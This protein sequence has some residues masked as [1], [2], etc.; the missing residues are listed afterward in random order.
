M[1]PNQYRPGTGNVFT[2]PIHCAHQNLPRWGRRQFLSRL[3]L[4]AGAAMAL[5]MGLFHWS[6]RQVMA[7][8]VLPG[9]GQAKPRIRAGFTR[10]DRDKYW[11]GWPGAA[12]DIAGSQKRYTEIL[13]HAAAELGVTLD[14]E[15]APLTNAEAIDN[16]LA[17]THNDDLA[18][19]LLTVMSLNEGWTPLDHFLEHRPKGLPTVVFAPQGTQFTPFL[20]QRR[21]VPN[22]FIGSTHDIRWLGSG[23]RMLKARWQMAH[24]RLAVIRGDQEREERLEPVGTT[25]H[26][27]PL[28]WFADAYAATAS[29]PEVR[30]L[31]ASYRENASQTVE[32]DW[33]ELIEAARTYVANR[34]LMDRTGCHAVTM[35]CLG[36]VNRRQTPPPC[37]AYMQL[38]DEQTCGCCEA[39]IFPAISLLLSSYLLGRP[40]FLHNPT[41]NTVNNTYGG[42]HCTAPTLLSGFD[43]PPEPYLL[44]NHHESDWGV[45]PQVIL[46]TDH[47]ATLLRFLSPGKFMAGTGV[48]LRNI[49]TQPHDGV[50]GCRTAFEMRMDDV[51]DVRDIR[52]HHNV[53]IYGR[54]L[55]TLFGWSQLAGIEMEPMVAPA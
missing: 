22:C 30:D 35:D 51:K 15:S 34:Q 36:L 3:T 50:G 48:I 21:D 1:N 43:Q 23:L 5:D 27:M 10:P 18:G 6:T 7:A 17:A 19:A 13:T 2:C 9:N 37:M 44:R 40:A 4:A 42:A 41:P 38:L 46:R 11:M 25:L 39:D 20:R 53:L 31:A 14:L 49:N 55:P 12:Y 32:P 16:F 8:P 52:G 54:H 33:A 29:A 28:Q 45:A 26:H 47:P 24:S